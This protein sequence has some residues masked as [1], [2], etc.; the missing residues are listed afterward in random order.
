MSMLELGQGS[1]VFRA[2]AHNLNDDQSACNE[3]RASNTNSD[4]E[5]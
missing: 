4:S 3:Q 2:L 5:V 1:L